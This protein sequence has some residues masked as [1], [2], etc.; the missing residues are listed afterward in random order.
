MPYTRRQQET[1]GFR[2][3][4]F[5]VTVLHEQTLMESL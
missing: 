1:T 4:S 3:F 5:K 2:T